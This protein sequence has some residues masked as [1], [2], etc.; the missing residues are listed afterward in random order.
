MTKSQIVAEITKR[1]GD[2]DAVAYGT[3]SWNYFIQAFYELVPTLNDNEK[4]YLT[5][6]LKINTDTNSEGVINFTPA[7]WEQWNDVYGVSVNEVPSRS[8][9]RDEFYKMKTNDL[10]YP[11]DYESYYIFE[12]D[13]IKVLTGLFSETINMEI[14]YLLDAWALMGEADND[15]EIS[16]NQSVVFRA[17]PVAT[18]KL[19]EQ[20]GLS[21]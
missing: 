11:A 12:G 6:T 8:I 7:N 13:K 18:E 2:P 9:D 17:I 19:K 21:M 10:Y 14:Y 3:D 15:D 5:R 4:R 16:I 20:I 1:V